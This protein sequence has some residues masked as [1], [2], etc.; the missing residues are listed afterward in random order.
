MAATPASFGDVRPALTTSRGFLSWMTDRLGPAETHRRLWHILPGFLPFLLWV[1]PHADY[2]KFWFVV[3]VLCDVSLLIAGGL[4][5]QKCLLRDGESSIL[6]S[7]LGYSVAVLPMILLFPRQLELG[8][9]TF[10]IIAFGDGCATLFGL[11]VGG[12]ALPWNHCK[13]WAGTLAFVCCGTIMGTIVY[14][15]E[16]RPTVPIETSWLVVAGGVLLAA[17]VESL[18]VSFNDNLRVGLAAAAGLVI[19]QNWLVGWP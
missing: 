12:R 8:M 14:W 7:V 17:A 18:P 2:L 10:A 4:C 9:T 11:L 5:W 1:I 15:G 13:T 6:P 3:M 19:M 16:A